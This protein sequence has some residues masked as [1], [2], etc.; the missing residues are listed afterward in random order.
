MDPVFYAGWKAKGGEQVMVPILSSSNCL[1]SPDT[2]A[3]GHCGHEEWV[4]LKASLGV[5][6]L[7]L[8]R[9]LNPY[10]N[11][12]LHG[13]RAQRANIWK[14]LVEMAKENGGEAEKK[15][16][17]IAFIV[18]IMDQ[19]GISLSKMIEI[20]YAPTDIDG[21]SELAMEIRDAGV[22][23]YFKNAHELNRKMQKDISRSLVDSLWRLNFGEINRLI[24]QIAADIREGGDRCRPSY[25]L[26][27]DLRDLLLAGIEGFKSAGSA[28]EP[29]S[30][31]QIVEWLELIHQLRRPPESLRL[32]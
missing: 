31:E 18:S 8:V 23:D 22:G 12:R 2:Y 9:T 15:K 25:S 17:Q 5:S 14:E 29:H 1:V 19:Y 4:A 11:A 13:F 10:L 26:P 21:A 3:E 20:L 6:V 28:G 7:V 16:G 30:N 32:E 24:K 27:R